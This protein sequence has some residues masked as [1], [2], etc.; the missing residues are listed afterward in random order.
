LLDVDSSMNPE[1]ADRGVRSWGAKSSAE[2]CPDLGHDI[3]ALSRPGAEER[4]QADHIAV[5]D[6]PGLATASETDSA[7]RTAHSGTSVESA[8]IRETARRNAQSLVK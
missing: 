1:N 5:A 7:V 2:S 3:V 4:L 6:E 8:S